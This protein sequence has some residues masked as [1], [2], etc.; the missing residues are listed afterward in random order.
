MARILLA[1]DDEAVRGPLSAQLNRMG[2]D[3]DLAENGKV[4]VGLALAIE[5]DLI[6]SDIRMPGTDGLQFLN[7]VAS[8]IEHVTPCMVLTGYHD[9]SHAISAMQAGAMNYIRKPWDIRDMAIAV[10]QALTKRAEMKFRRDYQADLER[11]IQTALTDLKSGYDATVIGFAALCEGKDDSTA[12]HC[13]RVR[14][15]CV[16]L[17]MEMGLGTDRIRDL[18][19][20]AMLHDIGKVKI[21][22]AILR[23]NGPL[24]ADEWTEMRKH[25]EYGAEIVDKI[26]FVRRAAPILRSH[27]EKWD[28]SGYPSGLRGDQIPLEA[29]IFMVVDAY[30]AITSKRHYKEAQAPEH[31]L[32][33]IQRC[34]GTHFDPKVVEVFERIYPEIVAGSPAVVPT[35]REASD[36]VRVA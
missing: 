35:R 36:R 8:R 30:D 34:V 4:A 28:G 20:G 13:V 25:A 1:D 22:D 5:Y 3:V 21:P 23:K 15:L 26:D 7:A 31:A 27:H 32:R 6:I 33:E 16:R 17:G 14:D 2:H 24:T 12:D 10:N 29:R 11:R 18:E 9:V 19:L